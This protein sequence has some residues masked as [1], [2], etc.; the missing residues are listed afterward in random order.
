[1]KK[2]KLLAADIQDLTVMASAMQDAIVNIGGIYFDKDARA[3]TLRMTR[4][5]YEANDN[6]NK[7]R[8]VEAGLR[9]DG[10][11]S[12]QSQGIDR[13]N[14]ASFM[15]ILDINFEP[16]AT[17]SDD[18]SGQLNILFA[19]GG[20]LRAHIEALDLILADTD[21]NRVTKMTPN[22]DI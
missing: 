1:M 5:A 8:R 6:K 12:L 16:S 7:P 3:L 11:L 20:M 9:I 13:K 4:Y 22:H 18:P 21:N 10:I 14:A 2:L 15:V 19:G 17:P